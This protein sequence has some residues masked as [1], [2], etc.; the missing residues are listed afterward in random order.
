[1]VVIINGSFGVGKTTVAKLLRD[2]LPG[3]IVYD[4][5][6][7]G[8][9]LQRLPRWIRLKGG[10]TDDFQDIELWRRLTVMGVSLFGLLARGSVIVPMAFSNYS[11]LDEIVAGIR[12]NQ[13]ATRIFCLRAGLPTIER[14][15]AERG[16]KIEG[17]GSEWLARRIR[18][19]DEAHRDARFGE[20]VETEGRPPR[21]V[22][23]DILRRLQQADRDAVWR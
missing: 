16:A 8:V 10:R 13:P 2:S 22:A 5:E 18:E 4:P 3:S 9:I 15:L 17:P 11:Y 21:A 12:G 1:M 6:W 23:A 7:V 19:C 14:R 20:P